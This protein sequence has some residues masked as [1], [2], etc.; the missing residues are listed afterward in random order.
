[1]VKK[2]RKLIM[3]LV[4]LVMGIGM[5]IFPVDGN[6]GNTSLPEK[7]EAFLTAIPFIPLPSPIALP[8][9]TPIPTPTKVPTPTPVPT[10]SP[11]ENPLLSEV[12]EDILELVGNYFDSRLT[13]IEDYK[14]LI[15]ND[16]YVD[17]QLTY[18]RVE[19]IVAFH[20]IKCYCKKGV[21]VVDYVVYALNDAEIATIDTYAP[22]ID[23]LFIKYDDNKVPKIYLPGD[24]LSGEEEAYYEKLSASEDVAA[25]VADVNGRLGTAIQ[26][27]ADLY[28]FLMRIMDASADNA[29]E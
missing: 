14:K 2:H 15:Y 4:L 23:Q 26:E 27:D 21:G 19:Y 10:L 11:A 9:A 3:D 12:P 5:V 17:E 18:Q 28:D 1:M 22:S 29:G 25:L 8:S 6:N 24:G 7:G 20:N 13:S 16:E